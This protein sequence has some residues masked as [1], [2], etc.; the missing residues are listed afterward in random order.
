[1]ANITTISRVVWSTIILIHLA[2][3]ILAYV[4]LTQSQSLHLPIPALVVILS[5]LV[6][7]LPILAVVLPALLSILR[8]RTRRH[9][10][11]SLTTQD[12]QPHRITPLARPVI[13]VLSLVDISLVA[14]AAT[15]VTSISLNC[16]LSETWSHLFRSKNAAAIRT[17]Q[18]T[19]ACC[20]FQSP[21]DQAYPFPDHNHGADACL[22]TFNRD[23]PCHPLLRR[24]AQQ[25]LGT[26][27]AVGAFA[28]AVKA[29]LTLFTTRS[30]GL[31]SDG[32]PVWKS[33][34]PR[35]LLDGANG[36][37]REERLDDEA[38]PSGRGRS[39]QRYSDEGPAAA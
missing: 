29:V 37:G 32:Q 9:V 19:L 26:F 4:K 8:N 23:V 5:S 7:L 33:R 35:A 3:A 12:E 14:S 20:G 27:I 28:L 25:T 6:P 30:A 31:Q 11:S 38:G 15:A 21:R 17:I 2:L 16:S 34:A 24:Q 36:S 13:A 18:D 1:M 22:A 39:P 10:I